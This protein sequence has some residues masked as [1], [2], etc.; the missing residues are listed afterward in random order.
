MVNPSTSL[1]LLTLTVLAV[2]HCL[3]ARL[4]SPPEAAKI[5]SRSSSS[6]KLVSS[7]TRQ[8]TPGMAGCY[9]LFLTLDSGQVLPVLFNL[10]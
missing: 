3:E 1:R 4:S 5:A 2:W 6:G 10:S 7:A 8:D 9:T